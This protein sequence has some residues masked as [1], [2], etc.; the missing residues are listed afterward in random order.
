MRRPVGSGSAAANRGREGNQMINVSNWFEHRSQA[1]TACV[2]EVYVKRTE[3][4]QKDLLLIL[5]YLAERTS[6]V[7]A[8]DADIKKAVDLC[9][10][11]YKDLQA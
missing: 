6:G 3:Q 2:A 11:P 7:Q 5:D 9:A 1:H 4:A 10:I 8:S